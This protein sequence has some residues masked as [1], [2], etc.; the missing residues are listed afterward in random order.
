MAMFYR[1]VAKMALRGGVLGP[2]RGMRPVDRAREGHRGQRR[3]GQDRQPDGEDGEEA[4]RPE[5]EYGDR[6]RHPTEPQ[7]PNRAVRRQGRCRHQDRDHP[8]QRVVA[9][10]VHEADVHPGHRRGDQGGGDG[11]R[12][13][14]ERG[15]ITSLRSTARRHNG[16]V[17][18]LDANPDRPSYRTTGMPS[19][20]A[21]AAFGVLATITGPAVGHLVAAATDPASSPVLAVGSTVIDLTPTPV[22]DWAVAEFGT[23]DKPILIGSVLL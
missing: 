4:E 8:G 13:E 17:W 19:R 20:L 5:Q 16:R 10:V 1:E 3:R 6:Q 23:K 7:R 9:L 12:I 2:S 15:H 14:P 22:K 18:A 11:V 21:C